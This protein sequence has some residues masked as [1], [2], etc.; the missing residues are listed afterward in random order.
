MVSA[1]DGMLVWMTKPSRHCCE[2]AKCGEKHFLCSRKDKFGLNLQAICDDKLR[3]TWVDIRWPGSTSDYMAWMTSDLCGR[4]EDD[5]GLL[6]EGK[7]IVRDNAYVKKRYMSVPHKG[8]VSQYDDAYNFTSPSFGSTLSVHL[9]LWFIGG[10]F[11][12]DLYVRRRR[13]WVRL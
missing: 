2:K 6:L 11:Y 1:I 8:I 13:R 5:D 3:F 4:L 9:E 12:G 10:R 7:F